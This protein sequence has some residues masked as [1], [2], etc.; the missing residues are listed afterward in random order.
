MM[1]IF[2]E[3]LSIIDRYPDTPSTCFDSGYTDEMDH[4]LWVYKWVVSNCKDFY[5]IPMEDCQK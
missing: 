4:I 1:V 5:Q 3:V 2:P